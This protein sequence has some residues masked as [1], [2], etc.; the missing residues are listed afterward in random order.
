M[1]DQPHHWTFGLS[2]VSIAIGTV[3]FLDAM[4]SH[5]KILSMRRKILAAASELNVALEASVIDPDEL[6]TQAARFDVLSVVLSVVIDLE[7][8]AEPPPARPRS[9]S[10]AISQG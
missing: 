8:I 5:L 6:A 3:G 7:R 1:I 2:L 9:G 10:R 4:T